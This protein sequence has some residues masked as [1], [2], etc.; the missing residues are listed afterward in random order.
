MEISTQEQNITGA[1]KHLK[2]LVK[3]FCR[4]LKVD[5]DS[6]QTTHYLPLLYPAT[7]LISLGEDEGVLDDEG[8]PT[9]AMES[10]SELTSGE[11][12]QLLLILV[13]GARI[14]REQKRFIVL[15]PKTNNYIYTPEQGTCVI[16]VRQFDISTVDKGVPVQY[17]Y[18]RQML[19]DYGVA[20][21]ELVLV[22]KLLPF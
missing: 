4:A 17:T 7:A 15:V 18:T 14:D 13:N 8:D 6:E 3:K 5:E 21:M 19:E 20:D 16:Q 11:E 9:P 2:L 22:D 1:S 10:M 12:E